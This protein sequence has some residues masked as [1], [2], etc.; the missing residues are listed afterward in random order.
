MLTQ[1]LKFHEDIDMVNLKKEQLQDVIY[2][3]NESIQDINTIRNV[4]NKDV[5]DKLTDNLIAQIK[6]I[7]DTYDSM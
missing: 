2:F 1:L 6:I 5:V 4:E 3:L 7:K